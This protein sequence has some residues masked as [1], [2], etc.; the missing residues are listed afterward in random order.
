MTNGETVTSIDSNMKLID[1]SWPNPDV[2]NNCYSA[3]NGG[4]SVTYLNDNDATDENSKAAVFASH[5]YMLDS[6]MRLYICD[7]YSDA[8]CVDNDE[9]RVAS[10]SI[11]LGQ[12]NEQSRG[13]K[14]NDTG[15]QHNDWI[16][17]LVP[18][19][20]VQQI[21]LAT[22]SETYRC[23]YL[24]PQKFNTNYQFSCNLHSPNI[25]LKKLIIPM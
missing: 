25:G 7:S 21:T 20:D 22:H 16:A 18:A 9:K 14:A 3:F 1:L 11:D 17:G 13:A 8:D 6:K 12:G 10:I 24:E 5:T 2:R 15:C 19:N 4:D 23:Y